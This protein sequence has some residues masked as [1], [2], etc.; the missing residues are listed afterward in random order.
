MEARLRV[1][2]L[3]ALLTATMVAQAAEPADGTLADPDRPI[4]QPPI[5]RR[6]VDIAKIDGR[7]FELGPYMG[8]LSVEDFGV[9]PVVGL[10]AAY[11]VTEDFFIEAAAGRADTQ[12]TSYERLSGA[13]QLLTEEQRRFSYYNMAAGYN[14]LPGEAFVGSRHAFN[15]A[16]YLI[17]GIG[18]TSFGGSDRFTIN[19]GFGYRIIANRWL[20]LHLGMRNYTFNHDLL[21]SRKTTNN[22]E[23][24]AAATW[25]F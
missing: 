23:L 22:L 15:S 10:R 13:A 14:L 21:G 25:I 2:L 18:V 4:F 16:L 3:T 19:Y 17:G 1:L 12:Q 5:E 20:A 6:A 9:N 11:H 7:D 8:L 24:Q